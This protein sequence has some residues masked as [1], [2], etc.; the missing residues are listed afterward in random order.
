[1]KIFVSFGSVPGMLHESATPRTIPN[2]PRV[3]GVAAK[4]RKSAAR[5]MERA[6]FMQGVPCPQGNGCIFAGSF[7]SYLLL[8]GVSIQTRSF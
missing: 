6:G 1:M 5:K 4:Q 8:V 2:C 7:P 3:N